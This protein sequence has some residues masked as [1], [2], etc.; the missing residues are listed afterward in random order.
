M[1]DLNDL[2]DIGQNISID[3]TVLLIDRNFEIKPE[4]TIY[5]LTKVLYNRFINTNK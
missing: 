2:N 4:L 5:I 1:K 3:S